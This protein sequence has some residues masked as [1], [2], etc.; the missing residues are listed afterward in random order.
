MADKSIPWDEVRA[1]RAH[2]ISDAERAAARRELLA[3]RV[4]YRLA[5]IR[6]QAGLTQ[7][8]LA[9]EMGVGQR[10]VSAIEHGNLV[11]TE[12]G[13]VRSYVEALGGRVRIVA[14]FDGQTI[15]LDH[16]EAS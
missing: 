16:P 12:L 13:T 2:E 1:A 10:R 11:R 14:D 4:A 8:E 7:T 15:D 9:A 5:Q 3:E 6:K